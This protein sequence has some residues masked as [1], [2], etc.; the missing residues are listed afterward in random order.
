MLY[1]IEFAGFETI[2][3]YRQVKKDWQIKSNSADRLIL[4]T[5]WAVAEYEGL[6]LLFDIA[7]LKPVTQTQE[8]D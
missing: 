5:Q 8:V 1:T 6:N 4:L 3:I 7:S 2:M